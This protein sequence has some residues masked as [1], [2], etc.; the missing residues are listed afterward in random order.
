M[1]ILNQAGNKHLQYIRKEDVAIGEKRE[2]I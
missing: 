1:E 2:Y